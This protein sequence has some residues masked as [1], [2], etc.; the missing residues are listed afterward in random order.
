MTMTEPAAFLRPAGPASS[1]MRTKLYR[2]RSSSDVIPR[3]RLLERLNAGLGGKV[4]LVS[5]PAGFGKTTLMTEWVQTLDRPTTWLSLDE[6]DN[7]LAI[8][9]YSLTAALQAVFPDAFQ[10]T[11]SLLKAPQFPSPDHAATLFINDL[12]DLPEDVVLVLDD[13]HLIHTNEVHTLL[14]LLIEHLPS[15]LH[16]VLSTR[17]DPPLPLARWRARGYLNELRGADLRFTLEE[18]EAFLTRALDNEVAHETA[19]ALEDLTEGW[20]AVL[21]LA[22]LSLRS[23][24]DRV[25]F[26]ERLRSSPDQYMS[27]YLVEEVLAR[28]APAVQELLVRTS[29]LEQ[30]CAGLCVAIL[31]S[32]T[33][34]AQVQATLDWLER[35]NLFL[36]PLDERQGWYRFHHLFKG[37]LQQRLQGQSSQEELALLHRRASAWYAEQGRLEEALEHALA[38]GDVANAAR[39]VEAQFL[40]AREQ[41]QWVQME[42]WL[43]LLPAEQI[44]SSPVLLC[45][46]VWIVWARG[47]LTELPRLLTAAERLLATSDSRASD[48]NTRQSRLQ[49]ALIAIS[50]S[51]FQYRTGQAQASLASALSALEWLPPGEEQVASQALHY[52]AISSQLNGQEDVALIELNNALRDPS[53]HLTSTARLLFAQALVYLAAGKLHQVEHTAR[54]LLRLSQEADLALSQI[55]PTGC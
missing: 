28:Q 27:S 49:H 41:E 34:N 45:A 13:Y 47:Q 55:M 44:Q 11:A 7:E 19:V 12:A 46:R 50:W 22:A 17:S 16:L 29:I 18:T 25:A 3:A 42:R 39:L 4:T 10:S 24:A 32:D 30:F 26:M 20:I 35:A 1:L 2:P 53:T 6:N 38:A 31:G 15:Q 40:P 36:I 9:V 48:A 54:H 5:A 23:T 43:R 21:R 37:L 51:H 8:F 52:L 33:S 14:N